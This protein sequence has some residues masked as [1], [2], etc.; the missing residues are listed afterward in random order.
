MFCIFKTGGDPDQR[1]EHRKHREGPADIR[2][3]NRSVYLSY[4]LFASRQTPR[5]E[6]HSFHFTVPTDV[7]RDRRTVA[8]QSISQVET[9]RYRYR[10]Y[11]SSHFRIKDSKSTS[12]ETLKFFP[13]C[14]IICAIFVILFSATH[15]SPVFLFFPVFLLDYNYMYMSFPG[16]TF[17]KETIARAHKIL[18]QHSTF[19]IS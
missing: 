13:G 11:A 3:F 7:K 14:H 9:G 17:V 16:N 19:L 18:E 6:K 1:F 10:C 2:I 15:L 12:F 8:P 5:T 4:S